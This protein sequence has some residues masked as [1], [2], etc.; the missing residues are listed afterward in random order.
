LFGLLAPKFLLENPGAFGTINTH[1][2]SLR[3]GN[4]GSIMSK[5][6]GFIIFVCASILIS[7]HNGAGSEERALISK[8]GKSLANAVVKVFVTT[9]QMDYYR[10]WQSKGIKASAGSGA[11]IDGNRILTNA[12]VVADHTFIQVKKDADPKKYSAKLIAIGHDCDLALLEVDDPAFF[13]GVTPLEFGKLPQQRDS[14]TVI[15]FPEGGDKI[16]I[17]EGVVSRIEVTNYAQSSRQLLTVQIDAAINPGNSGGPVVQDGK[18]VGIAMQILQVGQNI[19][20][21]IPTPIIDHFLKD[22]KDGKYDGFPILGIDFMSTENATLREFYGITKETGGVLVSKVLPYSPAVGEIWSG[23]ILLEIN[24]IP[25]GED[26]TFPFRGDQRLSLTHLITV[27]YIGDDIDLKIMRDKKII[28][29]KVRL[30]EYVTLVPHSHYFERPPYYIFG[31]LVFTVLSTDLTYS[32]GN[33]W[34]EKAPLDF[35]HYSIGSGR[36]NKEERKEVVVMLNVLPDDVNVGYHGISNEVVTKVNR[37]EIGSF[38]EFVRE[39]DGGKDS[40]SYTII[41][42]EH[43]YRIILSNENIDEINTQ[44]LERNSIPY[45]FPDIVARW[46]DEAG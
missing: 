27:E 23:D 4:S 32:W 22:L 8:K 14:V 37:K 12:H 33:R 3:N 24:G 21:M 13:K 46:L 5:K 19:G 25:I 15:G 29:A 16:S 45:Q 36:L 42:T 9:N 43:Q 7:P 31:G 26:G 20:Y 38:R 18:L 44:I 41:E 1:L 34:W 10:P 28:K 6:A 35:V 11:V 17:T 40:E 2:I 39:V 30:E